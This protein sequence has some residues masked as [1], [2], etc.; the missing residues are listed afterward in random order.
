M[1]AL[2]RWLALAACLLAG[3]AWAQALLP[4]PAL[5]ARV[6]DQTATLSPAQQQALEAKLAAFEA[7][8]GPQIVI[9]LV[10][11]TAP[12]DIAAFAFRVA[13]QWKIGRRGV[14][15]GLLVLVAKDDRVARI[16]VARALEGA[17]PDLAARQ[18]I[19]RAMVPAFRQG[20]YAG[21]LNLAVDQLIGRISGE[22]LPSPQAPSRGPRLAGLDG[23]PSWIWW[24]LL[25]VPLAISAVR[26]ML[27]PGAGALLMGGAG[28]AGGWWLASLGVGLVAGG[29]LALVTALGVG[30]ALRLVLSGAARGGLGGGGG[31]G[32]FSSG[33]GGS[34]GGG[35]A[36]GRW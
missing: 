33:G 34:F 27:G 22:G 1:R 21:G 28:V 20:D 2:L 16:E 13:D 25:A 14:G 31:G 15:D 30:E 6:I 12:E 17:V 5:T 26:A 18:V 36:S 24:A 7:Q 11:S 23:L 10:R 3:G 4:V 32:G 35:G 8:S 19:D 29:V 9:L